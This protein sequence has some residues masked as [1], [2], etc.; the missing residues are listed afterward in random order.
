MYLEKQR[1]YATAVRRVKREYEQ[2]MRRTL[3]EKAGSG[4]FW[5]C[6]RAAGLT[7]KSR[8]RVNLE[9]V[10][11]QQGE[12]KTEKD[13]VEVWRSYFESLLGGQTVQPTISGRVGAQSAFVVC[14]I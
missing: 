3:E 2:S 4:D 1:F 9:E 7:N 11:N 8:H 12:I 5:K 14:W 6:V 10:Y 13:A